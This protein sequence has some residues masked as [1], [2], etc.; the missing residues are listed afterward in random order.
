MGHLAKLLRRVG[1]ST[2]P[3]DP[4]Y[5]DTVII[6]NA[7]E[8]NGATSFINEA[9]IVMEPSIN[10]NLYVQNNRI[11]HSVGNNGRLLYNSSPHFALNQ[12][13]TIECYITFQSSYS[14]FLLSHSGI[15][16]FTV[17]SVNI[18]QFYISSNYWNIYSTILNVGTRYHLA[19]VRTIIDNKNRMFIDG[20]QV[21]E[22]TSVLN[23]VNIPYGI[24]GVGGRDDLNAPYMQIEAFRYTK[25]ARY[26]EDFTPPTL[27]F[28]NHS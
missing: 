8:T 7:N 4:F 2:S 10:R 21:R 6:L 5:N 24:F 13:L 22:G 18:E 23:Y 1:G 3:G 11:I 25:A 12:D 27:P 17:S 15:L 14:G 20:V 19:I 9:P 16:Y 28:P 26:I